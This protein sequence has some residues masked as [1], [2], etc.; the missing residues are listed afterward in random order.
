VIPCDADGPGRRVPRERCM[1]FAP[2]D[3]RIGLPGSGS[4]EASHL[5]I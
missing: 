4:V 3:P 1:S 2:S 5:L